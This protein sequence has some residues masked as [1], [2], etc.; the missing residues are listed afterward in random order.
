MEIFF[1]FYD[2][3]GISFKGNWYELWGRRNWIVSTCGNNR[4]QLSNQR[5]ISEA[6]TLGGQLWISIFFTLF[7]R[8]QLQWG[9]CTLP[10]LPSS[11]TR[12]CQVRRVSP[13]PPR[14]PPR[15][16]LPSQPPAQPNHLH[17]HG[18]QQHQQLPKCLR[19]HNQGG[20]KWL[21]LHSYVAR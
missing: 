19:L 10:S 9:G 6:A 4:P 18:L 21:L 12:G 3:Y 15:S 13:A 11:S 5:P 20:G 2:Q 17:P 1:R 7:L 14:T 16:R 8:N